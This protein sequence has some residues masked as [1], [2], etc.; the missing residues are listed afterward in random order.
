MKIRAKKVEAPKVDNVTEVVQIDDYTMEQ[1]KNKLLE[2]MKQEGFSSLIVYA[3]KE[4]GGN[5]EYLTGFIPRFE[6]GIQIINIDGSSILILGNENFNKVEYSRTKSSGIKCTL[7]SLPNQ[8]INNL[9]EMEE[10]IRKS[11]IDTTGKV[12]IVGWKIL[13]GMT[14]DYDIPAFII[15]AIK[16]VI[17]EDKL[18]NATYLYIDPSFGVRIVNNANEIAHFEYGASLASDSVLNAMNSLEVGISEQ[19][20]GNYL[21]SNGFFPTVVTI[22]TFGPRFIGAN[23]YPTSRILKKGDKVALT[24]AYR[25]GLSSRNGYAVETLEQLEQVD[26]GYFEDVMLPYFHAYNFWLENIK[27][28][29]VGGDFYKE[30]KVLYPQEVFGWEL[31]PGHLTANEEWLCSPL[32]EGSQA[33]IQSGMIFQIDFIPIQKGH[34]GVS[35]ESTVAVADKK[36]R[37]NI[38]QQYPELWS[39]IIGR[40]EYLKSNL[41]IDLSEELLPLAGTLA[42]YRPFLLDKETALVFEN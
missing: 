15:A 5:F 29:V 36:L 13:P 1:R 41:G 18:T 14:H 24:V 38:A 22:S 32:Y 25:G 4:H 26:K 9:D 23:L 31:N 11:Q 37:Q 27:I 35:A 40:R 19:E 8:P 12:G 33:L 20:T 42:Y 3:D 39:R 17:P 28:G 10:I 16:K 21:Q 30:F 2:I 6:E 7:F 34:N